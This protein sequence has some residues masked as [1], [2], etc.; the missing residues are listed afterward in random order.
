MNPFDAAFAIVVGS[1][2]EYSNN[3]GDPGNW[4]AGKVG[5]GE[6]RGTKFGISAAAFPTLDIPALTVE[7]AKRIYH[8]RYWMPI[9]A[10]ALPTLL[11]ILLFDAAVNNGPFLAATFLQAAVGTA[12]DG[13][14]GPETIRATTHAVACM[15]LARLCG[16]VSARRLLFMMKLPDWQVF[17]AGWAQRLSYLPF[18]ATAALNGKPFSLSEHG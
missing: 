10:D 8:L 3:P 14:I 13:L 6:L 2:G 7:D 9:S 15:G 17:G 1:E 18:A 11:A 12:Q 5:V 4:T 16:E